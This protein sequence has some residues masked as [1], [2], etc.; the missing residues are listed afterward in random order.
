MLLLGFS[1]LPFSTRMESLWS[2]AGA[3]TR[4]RPAI[5]DIRQKDSMRDMLF[6]GAALLLCAAPLTAQAQAKSHQAAAREMHADGHAAHGAAHDHAA[7]PGL[8]GE[9]VRD[10]DALE[11]KYVALAEAI[12]Q[13]RYGWRPM[14]GVRS[15]AEVFG[16]LAAANYAIPRALGVEPP[17][18]VASGLGDFEAMTEKSAIVEALR[19]SFEHARHAIHRMPDDGMDRSTRLF[20]QEFSHRGVALLTVNHMH[21]HLGQLIAYARGNEI[22]PPWNAGE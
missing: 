8:Q 19:D 14:E 16:H 17:A 15:V 4:L 1:V 13:E 21:E 9:L 18:D 11:R 10:I 5:Y 12:P 20:G 2:G 6:A 7:I 22:V 3:S